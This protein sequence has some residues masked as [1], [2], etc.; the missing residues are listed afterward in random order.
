MNTLY[1]NTPS[2]KNQQLTHEFGIK[3]CKIAMKFCRFS[4][5]LVPFQRPLLG[6]PRI[7]AAQIKSAQIRADKVLQDHSTYNADLVISQVLGVNTLVPKN[8]VNEK[9]ERPFRPNFS[10]TN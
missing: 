4:E 10:H 7:R 9:F 5:I 1:W 6:P 3:I 2:F 8:L